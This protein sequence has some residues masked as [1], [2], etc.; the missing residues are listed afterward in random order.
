MRDRMA[1]GTE[2]REILNLAALLAEPQRP[3]MVYLNIIGIL[4]TEYIPEVE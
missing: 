1:V 3:P 2:E 4:R